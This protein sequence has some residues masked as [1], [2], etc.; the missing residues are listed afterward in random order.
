MRERESQGKLRRRESAGWG[1]LELTNDNMK[2]QKLVT[3]GSQT[4][5]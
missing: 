3:R 1:N 5:F 2:L 4:F